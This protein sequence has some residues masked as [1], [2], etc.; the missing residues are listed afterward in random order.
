MMDA[1]LFSK[2]DVDFIHDDLVARARMDLLE[3]GKALEIAGIFQAMSDPTRVRLI[4][5]LLNTELCVCDLAAVL[6]MTQ[7]A[8]SHQL[9]L[10]RDQRILKA[11]R[12]G[13]MIFYSL[14]DE[15]VRDFIIRAKEHTLHG[16]DTNH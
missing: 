8:V 10:L 5:S 3:P 7:S 16:K 11:R 1:D 6:D 12:E 14:D 15:H 2:C 9:R 13:R 4:T